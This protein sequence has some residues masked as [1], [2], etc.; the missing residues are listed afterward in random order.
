M[1]NF[2][3]VRRMRTEDGG[4]ELLWTHR[5]FSCFLFSFFFF[6]FGTGTTLISGTL[7]GWGMPSR[8]WYPTSMTPGTSLSWLWKVAVWPVETEAMSSLL[9]GNGEGSSDFLLH[10]FSG[11]FFPVSVKNTH[12]SSWIALW[13]FPVGSNKPDSLPSVHPLS[14][15]FSS[16][17]QWFRSGQWLIAILISLSSACLSTP[18]ESSSEHIFSFLMQYGQA[19]NFPNF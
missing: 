12:I 8:L 18:L 4:S 9:L 15:P 13:C 17:W 14:V 5:F 16:N 7:S 10:H 3:L 6:F 1:I 2:E 11:Q 19:E